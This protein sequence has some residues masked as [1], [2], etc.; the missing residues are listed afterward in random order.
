MRVCSNVCRINMLKSF[1]QFKSREIYL[2]KYILTHTHFIVTNRLGS[3]LSFEGTLPV[4]LLDMTALCFA[5]S[6]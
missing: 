5:E 6:N 3:F 4:T 2:A 1:G